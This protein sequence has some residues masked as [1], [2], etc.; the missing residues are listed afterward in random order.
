MRSN[1][2]ARRAV[3]WL[4]IAIAALVE[5]GAGTAPHQ[6][7]FWALV[8]AD[9]PSD[10]ILDHLRD[11]SIEN[12]RHL[13]SGNPDG[14]GF[15]SYPSPP[16]GAPLYLPLARRGGPPADD[17]YDPDYVRAVEELDRVRPRAVLGHVRRATSGHTGIPDPHP[18]TRRQ[19]SFAHNGGLDAAALR[20]LL[21]D[22]LLTHPL[23]YDEGI[24][25]TG[26][27]DSE[28]YFAFLL[29]FAE[30]HPELRFAEALRQGVQALVRDDEVTGGYPKL[31]FVLSDGGT[32]YA[33][34]YYSGN[35]AVRFF[36]DLV[37]SGGESSYWVVSSEKV[38]SR[39]DGWG[40]VPARYLGVFV[41]NRVPEFLSIDA[42]AREGAQAGGAPPDAPR[43]R[44]A[45]ADSVPE[46]NCRFW[47]LVG[48]GYP[49]GLIP[50]HLRDGTYQNLKRLGGYNRDGWGLGCYPPDGFPIPLGDP[51]VR[52]GG[53]P[54]DDPNVAEYDI[55]V[56]E[57]SDLHPVAAIG[58][59]RAATSGHSGIPNPHPFQQRGM[60][61]AH[62]GGISTG[63]LLQRLGDYLI[64]HPPDYAAGDPGTGNIDSELY[65]LY[66]LKL[67]DAQSTSSFGA[68][69]PVALR[70][71]LADREVVGASP[72]LN[73]VLTDGD[74]LYAFHCY[75]S[76]SGNPVRYYPAVESAAAPRSSY[77]AVASEPL[78]DNADG[79]GTM[80][81]R[82]LGVFVP[83][84]APQFIQ[85][86]EPGL[87]E[88]HLADVS[89]VPL[90][91]QDADGW[92]SALEI[93]CDPNAQSG[94]WDVSLE[95]AA[96]ADGVTWI[97]L[98]STRYFGITG[99][100]PDTSCI[101]GFVVPDTL[102]PTLWDLRLRLRE[103]VSGSVVA[104]ATPPDFPMLGDWRVEGAAR[105]TLPDVPRR[106]RFT[107]MRITGGD[108][109]DR[110]GYARAF[111]LR[112]DVD[113]NTAHDSA[114]AYVTVVGM[115]G[116]G[117]NALGTS[118]VFWVRGQRPDSVDF[119]VTIAPPNRP[120]QSWDLYLELYDATA[121]TLAASAAPDAFPALSA[122]LVEGSRA[123]EPEPPP[124]DTL[125]VRVEWGWLNFAPGE[126]R[127]HLRLNLVAGAAVSLEVWDTAGR[128]VWHE[129]PVAR[130]PHYEGVL[131]WRGEDRDGGRVGS[132]VYLCR[133]R[134]GDAVFKRRVVLIR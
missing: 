103:S 82:T 5:G 60:L 121:D 96:T 100:A 132:G 88:F 24:G 67:V 4:S 73:F 36:P 26:P 43:A 55:S 15:V 98:G 69:L 9:Y 48:S 131:T 19:W 42:P 74:T 71:L 11:G 120:P 25:N 23:D 65:F 40:T 112:W 118:P 80:A 41:P 8:G 10:L 16:D 30:E 85:I 87:P 79:W 14:W 125:G 66:L 124:P 93:C 44:S 133:V 81:P 31:N 64:T 95:I 49:I 33:L 111:T 83:G 29:K 27:I 75:G 1:R 13:G 97:D 123:D 117:Y 108:D 76:G 130:E 77:W 114:Q 89:V 106:F 58:H 47:G 116:M 91:D 102:G 56:D 6:C 59:V 122:V 109:R 7:R 126:I 52:R 45:P 104:T 20:R 72:A 3:W 84:Q 63:M 35:S 110:D 86:G 22:Y 70:E 68:A 119:P 28:L 134:V 17:P 57:M 62:N 127:V 37:R 50:S 39:I 61:F 128:R 18:F 78:G 53:P 38:G 99:S 51:I 32:L 12:L 90:F 94:A 101:N 21:G 115:Q 2:W 105:D 54:A 92:A 34:H 107:G 113:L 129:G 46:H